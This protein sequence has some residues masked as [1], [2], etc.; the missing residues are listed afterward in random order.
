MRCSTR[1]PPLTVAHQKAALAL[2]RYSVD[3]AKHI[4]GDAEPDPIAQKIIG[5]LSTGPKTQNQLVNL[6]DRNVPRERLATVLADLQER[7]RITFSMKP[8]GGRPTR[9]WNLVRNERN[10]NSS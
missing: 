6:F 1:K 9:V 5:A 8:T 4:F 2:A 10:E 3:S 7:G